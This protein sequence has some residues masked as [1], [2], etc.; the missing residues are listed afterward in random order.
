[1]GLKNEN[2]AQGRVF[3]DLMVGGTRIEL[4]TPAV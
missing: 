1:M 4:V 3:E 2:P